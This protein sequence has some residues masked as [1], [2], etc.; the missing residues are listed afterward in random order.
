MYIIYDYKRCRLNIIGVRHDYQRGRKNGISF[1]QPDISKGKLSRRI[2]Y[3]T[4][5][6]PSVII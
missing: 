4:S 1:I 6:L 3:Y 5:I 2:E